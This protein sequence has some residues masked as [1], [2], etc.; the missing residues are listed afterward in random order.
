MELDRYV[1]TVALRDGRA[2][3]PTGVRSHLCA[4]DDGTIALEPCGS[5]RS[6]VE[7]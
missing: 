3:D 4:V 1:L 7:E 6:M 5:V 2:H